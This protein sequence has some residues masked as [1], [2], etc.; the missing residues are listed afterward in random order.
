MGRQGP[1][2][3]HFSP[4]TAFAASQLGKNS[5]G[6]KQLKKNAVTAAKVKKNAITA[7]KIKPGAVTGA[8]IDEGSL[9]TVPTAANADSAAVAAS[10]QGYQHNKVRMDPAGTMFTL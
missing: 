4:H 9:G 8:K 3:A 1:C 5:V 7:A 10:L 6:P 2:P